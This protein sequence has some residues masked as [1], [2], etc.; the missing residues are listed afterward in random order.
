MIDRAHEL[1]KVR[2]LLKRHRIVG[3][4]GARQVGKT[5]LARQTMAGWPGQTTFYDLEDPDDQARLSDPMLALRGRKGLIV[6]DEIQRRSDLF[7]VLRVLADQAAPATRYLVLG[8]ASPDLA[9][10]LAPGIRAI[11]ARQITDLPDH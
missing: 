10:D 4:L 6:I 2:L 3:L 5:T 7:P 11:G 1:K 9:Y 8:S